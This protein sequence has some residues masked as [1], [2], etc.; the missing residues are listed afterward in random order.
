MSE[1]ETSTYEVEFTFTETVEVTPELMDSLGSENGS[2]VNGAKNTARNIL[3]EA[4]AFDEY[5]DHAVDEATVTGVVE[6]R[7]TEDGIEVHHHS[8]KNPS[9]AFH[10]FAKVDPRCPYC[11]SGLWSPSGRFDW[12]GDDGG[13]VGATCDDCYESFTVQFR[14]VDVAWTDEDAN[15][16]EAVAEGVL[17]P[18]YYSYPHSDEYGHDGWEEATDD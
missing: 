8:A 10:R 18:T 17:A 6:K 7:P 13:V 15:R 5:P 1:D 4:P 2:G 3:F 9:E 14:A 16:F 12:T 11:D